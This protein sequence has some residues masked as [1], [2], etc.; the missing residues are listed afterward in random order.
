MLN[1]LKI[2]LVTRIVL[3]VEIF[4]YLGQ[5]CVI[6]AW[7]R[8]KGKLETKAYRAHRFLNVASGLI[9]CLVSRSWTLRSVR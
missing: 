2:K 7:K 9:I 6:R 5:P 8:A 4:G 3:K 1:F